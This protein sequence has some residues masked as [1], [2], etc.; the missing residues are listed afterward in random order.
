MTE[1]HQI[2]NRQYL[3]DGYLLVNRKIFSTA[4]SGTVSKSDA[5]S[6]SPASSSWRNLFPNNVA[7]EALMAAET[8][9]FSEMNYAVETDE[10]MKGAT[11]K[12]GWGRT[13][14]LGTHVATYCK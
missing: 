10:R 2:C 13:V 11:G 8:K 12:M 9:S 3:R 5:C 6:L 7:L 4:S 1:V 14:Q